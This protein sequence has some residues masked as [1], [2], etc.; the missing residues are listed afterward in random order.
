MSPQT[1]E[2]TYFL[3]DSFFPTDTDIIKCLKEFVMHSFLLIIDKYNEN[4]FKFYWF[5][6]DK[7]IYWVIRVTA[8]IKNSVRQTSTWKL[9]YVD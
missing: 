7:D 1:K 3:K 9:E 6:V 4:I 2:I 8:Q 5:F